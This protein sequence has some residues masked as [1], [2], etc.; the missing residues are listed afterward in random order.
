MSG[1][2]LIN[3]NND[4]YL[5]SGKM[6][7]ITGAL[8]GTVPVATITP[9][10]YAITTQV[11]TEDN[12]PV[13]DGLVTANYD[14]FTVTDGPS[15][16]PVEWVIDSAGK[17]APPPVA[18]RNSGADTYASLAAAITAVT[19]STDAAPD[20]ITILN[21]ITLDSTEATAISTAFV[22]GKHIKLT[23]PAG[24]TRT[25]K[26][27][28]GHDGNL[29]AVQGNSSLT[30]EGNGTG[31][32]EID[33]GAVWAGG[34][35]TP[36]DPANGATN[37]GIGCL[38]ANG[39]LINLSGGNLTLNAGGVLQNNG[40][41]SAGG[42]AV[43]VGSGSVFTMTGGKITGNGSSTAES[44]FLAKGGGVYIG[45]SGTF[46]M[47]GGLITGNKAAWGGGV[48]NE[49][50]T[51]NMSGSAVVAA[52]NDVYLPSGKTIT[53]TGTLSLPDGVTVAA[54]I[55]PADYTE[56]TQVLDGGYGTNYTKF[57]VTPNGATAW[58]VGSNGK[59]TTTPP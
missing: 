5:P 15:T 37:T 21:D 53:L 19:T 2:A 43:S 42:G 44:A 59:L 24:Q 55:R 6:I 58:Y 25:I 31:I 54:T 18:S 30:V 26:R 29:F 14:K 16:A 34:M 35:V 23:V 28:A 3:A 33:G 39:P 56:G 8:T 50:G 10:T 36:P 40:T 20:V 57:V 7:T 38:N 12:S 9:A 49:N 52:D 1:S 47:S 32:M 22:S 48:D 27:G 45:S 46:T 11:L 41:D 4:V 17:L 13:V 51:F